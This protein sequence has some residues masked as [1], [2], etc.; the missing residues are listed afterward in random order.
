M[1]ADPWYVRLDLGSQR[2]EVWSAHLL[3]DGTR[4]SL[5]NPLWGP[6]PCGDVR[7]ANGRRI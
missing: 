6:P 4:L 2:H 3:P 5:A 1:S 7:L